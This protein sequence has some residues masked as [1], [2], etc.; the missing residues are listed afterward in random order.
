M[1]NAIITK[2]NINA[3]QNK[4][5]KKNLN[6][7]STAVINGNKASWM[8]AF[9]LS[10]IITGEQFIDDFK[11]QTAF[12][13]F[14][15]TSK[16]T[17][18]Q[19]VNAVAFVKKMNLVEFDENKKPLVTLI[20]CSL[21]TAYLFSTIPADDFNDF[22]VWLWEQKHIENAYNISVRTLK[23]L[24]KEFYADDEEQETETQETETQ[25]TETQET[26]TEIIRD[27]V[28]ANIKALIKEYNI[29]ENE[30]F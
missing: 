18:T 6:A 17:I 12:A 26:E 14:I 15:D 13:K 8:Y 16:A 25:E 11:T 4:E 24:I 7:M 30:L 28:I 3:L 5:L 10:N 23:A 29:T 20:P 22:M 21:G 2:E 19:Y 1:D 27:E 9:H